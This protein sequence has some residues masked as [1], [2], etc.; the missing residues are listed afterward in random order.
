MSDDEVKQMS[1]FKSLQRRQQYQITRVALR[2]IVASYMPTAL[3]QVLRLTSN[4]FGN[5]ALDYPVDLL[6]VISL[7]FNLS[8]SVDVIVIRDARGRLSGVVI[9]RMNK[10][11][12]IFKI[13]AHYFHP[14]EWDPSAFAFRY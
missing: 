1:S 14:Q 6:D 13:A 10:P 12:D 5:P 11:R 2:M 7:H 4:H 9:E 3:T 8:H